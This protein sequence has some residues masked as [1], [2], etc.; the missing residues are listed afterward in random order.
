MSYRLRSTIAAPDANVTP[1][2]AA[3][4]AAIR[5][6]PDDDVIDGTV[7]GDELVGLAGDDI[8]YG[9]GGDDILVGNHGR[10]IL[11]GGEGMDQVSFA[12]SGGDGVTLDLDPTLVCY[13][14][15]NGVATDEI[16][17]M[18]GI[19]GGRGDDRF[20][21]NAA[22]GSISGGAGDD[23]VYWTDANRYPS[24]A[25]KVD[26]GGGIDT[27]DLS[28]LTPPSGMNIRMSDYAGVENLIGTGDSDTIRSSLRSNTLHGADGSDFLRTDDSTQAAPD[29][30]HG[31]AG[32]DILLAVS[33]QNAGG[34]LDGGRGDDAL[35]IWLD[36]GGASGTLEVAGGAGID[37][38]ALSTAN[39][40][41]DRALSITL[42]ASGTG[43][44][45]IPGPGASSLV[46][47]FSGIESVVG[48]G[49]NDTITGNGAAN[50]LYGARG[51][52]DV[53]G[54]AGDDWICGG[55]EQIPIGNSYLIPGPADDGA[56]R[57]TG[58]AGADRFGFVSINYGSGFAIDTITDFDRRE[59]DLIDLS[60]MDA[61]PRVSGRNPFVFVGT[62]AFSGAAGELRW[63]VDGADVLFQVDVTGDG[64]AD[65]TAR[66]A[67]M[68][69]LTAADFIL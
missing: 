29:R 56:D 63:S 35:M 58:G 19:I 7:I 66:V 42:G 11:Y 34:Y 45:S 46:V 47:S 64:R 4:L 69:D 16:H 31:D 20:S 68:A 21:L 5:G 24:P 38:L 18:E 61:K 13:A 37:T 39:P 50:V 32:N 57:L 36:S 53:Y 62:D 33:G 67:G 40:G 6:T 30:L 25:F 1:A 60:H 9:L 49:T 54:G 23:I 26:G 3:A 43:S 65:I 51:A 22:T 28:R 2:L 12:G 27:I 44:L 52:D 10:D 55:L 8:L 14:Y 17:E 48:G 15:V 59:G 41:G